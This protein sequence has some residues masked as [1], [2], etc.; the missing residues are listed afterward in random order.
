MQSY[1]NYRIV[2]Y[3]VGDQNFNEEYTMTMIFQTAS[4]RNKNPLSQDSI[5][6]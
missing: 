1:W 2:K 5:K 4:L 3:Q 6:D